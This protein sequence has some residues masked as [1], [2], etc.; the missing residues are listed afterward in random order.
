M[1]LNR[2][3]LLSQDRQSDRQSKKSFDATVVY[4]LCVTA[5]LLAQGHK[6]ILSKWVDTMKSMHDSHKPDW[7][8]NEEAREQCAPMT[9]FEADQARHA[10]TQTS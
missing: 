5:K 4:V 3:Q 6:P 9:N 1:H 8:W 7:C 2:F 10:K